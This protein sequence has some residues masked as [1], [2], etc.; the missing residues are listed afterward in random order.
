MEAVDSSETLVPI[1]QTT[2]HDISEDSKLHS[3]VTIVM[4]LG[5]V[6]LFR[7]S[8]IRDPLLT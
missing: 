8:N 2:G 7:K 6:C 1:H 4:I 5:I 3:P